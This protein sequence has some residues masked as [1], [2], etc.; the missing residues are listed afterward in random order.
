ML[1]PVDIPMPVPVS[2]ATRPC[3]RMASSRSSRSCSVDAGD[4]CRLSTG[5]TPRAPR[6]TPPDPCTGSLGVQRTMIDD[7]THHPGEDRVVLAR[8]T[9]AMWRVERFAVAVHTGSIVQIS[10]PRFVIDRSQVGRIPH[11]VV[12]PV[13]HHRVDAD[14]DQ[15]LDV[16]VVDLGHRRGPPPRAADEH[17]LAGAVDGQRRELRRRAQRPIERLLHRVAGR[18]Q[19]RD[20][21]RSTMPTASGPCASMTA[22]S[23]ARN[24]VESL[25]PTRLRPAR[26]PCASSGA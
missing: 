20:R 8:D 2:M 17:R 14:V 21:S 4:L 9:R 25:V 16:V 13:A 5:R 24:V 12:V 22:R 1:A 23:F 7:L 18:V 26:R 10:P 19:T 11:A 15:H 3:R 6:A